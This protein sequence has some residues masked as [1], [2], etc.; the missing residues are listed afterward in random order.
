[1]IFLRLENNLLSHFTVVFVVLFLCLNQ[2]EGLHFPSADDRIV[3]PENVPYENLF[4]E[5][6]KENLDLAWSTIST[7][8]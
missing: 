3:L 1:M 5:W 2:I 4:L 7:A 6:L 8:R